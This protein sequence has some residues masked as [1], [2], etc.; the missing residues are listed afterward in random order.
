MRTMTLI[1]Y[2][3]TGG[4][5]IDPTNA[6]NITI[7][8]YPILEDELCDYAFLSK[9][10]E[11]GITPKHREA[12]SKIIEKRVDGCFDLEIVEKWGL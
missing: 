10:H 7:K 3:N 1:Y 9:M 6:F 4:W 5:I 2:K 11:T 12:I 8:Q